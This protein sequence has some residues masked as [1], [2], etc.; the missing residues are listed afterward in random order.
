MA[1]NM[2]S[3]LLLS[4]SYLDHG[5]ESDQLAITELVVW[6]RVEA[7]DGRPADEIKNGSR[8]GLGERRTSNSTS[9]KIH[10]GDYFMLCCGAATFLD[11][12]VS[13]RPSF[14]SRIQPN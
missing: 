7:G 8:E 3:R 10:F 1:R 14:R 12:S 11:G 6:G 5:P 13:G 9:I 4:S 2:I